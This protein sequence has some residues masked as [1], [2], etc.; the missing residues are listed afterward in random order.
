MI[1]TLDIQQFVNSNLTLGLQDVGRKDAWFERKQVVY[2]DSGWYA[3]ANLPVEYLDLSEYWFSFTPDNYKDPN[4]QWVYVFVQCKMHFLFYCSFR[5]IYSK[6]F[7][8]VVLKTLS[9]EY[10]TLFLY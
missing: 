9:V 1:R 7:C 6:K 8:V 3:C 10:L 5:Y 4:V 2:G